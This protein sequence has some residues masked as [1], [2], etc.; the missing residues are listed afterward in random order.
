MHALL[1]IWVGWVLSGG[2]LGIIALMA[3][4]SSIFPVPS[5]IVIPPAAFLAA[6]GKLS[7]TGVV[8]AGTLGSY[9]GAVITYWAS[10]L[11]GRPLIVRYGRFVFIN[12]KKMEQAE[13]WLNRY[14]AGGVFFAR[15][16]P[17]VRHLISIPAG[18]VRMNFTFVT[19]VGSGIWCWILA[20]LGAKAYRLE[21]E[22]L[23]DP[24]KMIHFI[25]TQSYWIVLIVVLFAF[26]Y[27]LTL[28]LMRPPRQQVR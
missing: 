4:E 11:I 8:L 10:R 16:L 6:Q 20:Y 13:H 21:P 23:S 12:L 25:K 22:L 17:V 28:R 3:M 7:F 26:L 9:L 15:L 18:I 24:E 1:K 14:E 5:E 2:Y 27:L 19:I